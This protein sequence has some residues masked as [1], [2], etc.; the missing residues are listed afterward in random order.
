[1]YSNEIN[2]YLQTRNFNITYDE[3]DMIKDCSPQLFKIKFEGVEDKYS[4]YRLYTHD[5]FTWDVFV[6]NKYQG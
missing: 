5:N 2:D 4:R 6:L 1:M 3:I